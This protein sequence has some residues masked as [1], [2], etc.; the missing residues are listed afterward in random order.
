MIN[1]NEQVGQIVNN[2]SEQP[3]IRTVG[4]IMKEYCEAA[5]QYDKAVESN[6]ETDKAF[7]KRAK[8]NLKKEL[9]NLDS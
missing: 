5:T 8:E 3:P 1:I 6:K 4:D 2:T 7:W 9:E